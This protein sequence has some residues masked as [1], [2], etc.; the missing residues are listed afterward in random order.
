M[1]IR[2]YKSNKVLEVWEQDQLEI[3]FPIGIGKEEYGHKMFEGD[4][5]TPEGNY[6]ICVK[7][8]KSKFHLSL[9]LNYPN[10]EDA[11][12]ALEDRRICQETFDMISNS[13][14]NKLHPPWN[15]IL[16]GQIYIHGD[17]ETKNWSEGC[18]RMYKEDIEYLYQKIELNTEVNIYP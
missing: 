7:N 18:I 17:L 5:R 14:K 11:K 16:G 3:T 2:I 1:E 4:L 12:R 9:G 6:K 10:L 8:P 15:T 13:I